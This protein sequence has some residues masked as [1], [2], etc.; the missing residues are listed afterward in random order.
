MKKVLLVLVVL[1]LLVAGGVYLFQ[2]KRGVTDGA[3]LL[4][5]GTI[6][7]VAV[8]DVARTSLRWPETALAKIGAE[9]QV[10]EFLSRP[11]AALGD[12]GGGEA[13]Q[14]LARLKPGKF[15]AALVALG[16]SSAEG[17]LGFQY[18]GGREDLE[19]AMNRLHAE[20]SARFPGGSKSTAD[21][22]GDAVTSFTGGTIGLFT[23]SHGNWGLLATSE[24]ALHGMLDRAAGRDD[25]GS[26]ASGEEFKKVL[27]QL[28]ADPDFLWFAEF[29][30]IF[31]VLLRIGAKQGG[32][33]N[34]AQLA[35]V[36]KIKAAGGTLLLSGENQEEV[37]FVLMN[38][39]PKIPALNHS[40]ME[41]TSSDSTIFF[42][43]TLDLETMASAEYMASLPEP[44]QAF[45][46]ETQLDGGKLASLLGGEMG[47]VLK[48]SPGAMIPNLLVGLTIKDRARAEEITTA[49]LAQLG[50]EMTVSESKGAKIFEFPPLGLQIADPALAINDRFF[51]A[52]LTNAELQRALAGRV[53]GGTLKD[54]A[55]FKPALEAYGANDQVFAFIDT[56]TIFENVYNQLRPFIIITASMSPDL[57]KLID[58]DKL[59]ETEQISRHLA[60]IIYTNRQVADG[61]IIESSGPITFSQGAALIG[62]GIGMSMAAQLGAGLGN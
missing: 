9:S 45:L 3:A 28:P 41:L 24:A 21:Y 6:A 26:L 47:L 4:P 8:P 48:W 59:P 57:G 58:A 22:H 34:E 25:S 43:S 14:I 38:D 11:L 2:G 44:M 37:S 16:E 40:L 56:K 7:Y 29:E 31:D 10:A 54:A 23:A 39:M 42:E 5:L 33:V 32:S 35:Q 18:A 19:A 17:A 1:A 53:E 55:V 50:L 20:L 12:G 13:G 15:F 49:A 27:A 62:A 60:P 36:R 30:P 51:L 52:S 61:W 46:T